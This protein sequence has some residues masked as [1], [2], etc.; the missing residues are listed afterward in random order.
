MKILKEIFVLLLIAVLFVGIIPAGLYFSSLS[1]K[2][3]KADIDSRGIITQGKVVSRGYHHKLTAA[4]MEYYIKG[5]LYRNYETG[6]DSLYSVGDYFEMVIDSTDPDNFYVNW[7]KPEFAA[8][9]NVLSDSATVI[10]V[11]ETYDDGISDVRYVYS[12]NGKTFFRWQRVKLNNP[13][14]PQQRV[15]VQY[16]TDR[17]FAA[18]LVCK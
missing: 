15:K 2:K 10:E 6:G 8:G 5:K 14:L 4:E 9:S 17:P 3:N 16:A 11:Q 12:V 13:V 1:D 7:L 18:D